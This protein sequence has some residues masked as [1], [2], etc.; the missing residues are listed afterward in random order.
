[1]DNF[2]KIQALYKISSPVKIMAVFF[3]L[4]FYAVPVLIIAAWY[5]GDIEE[6]SSFMM[7]LLMAGVPCLLLGSFIWWRINRLFNC[8][9]SIYENGIVVTDIKGDH[10][11]SWNEIESLEEIVFRHVVNGIP[12]K[13]N[14]VYEI[15][16]TNREKFQIG[17]VFKESKEIGERLKA[18]AN[19]YDIPVYHQNKTH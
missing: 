12:T 2:G 19:K 7:L 4:F 5:N 17:N 10:P 13:L 11:A 8:R 9:V 6:Y 16:K 15:T 18:A 1:M 14:Y 3:I